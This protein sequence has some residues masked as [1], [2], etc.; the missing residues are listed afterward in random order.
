MVSVS[1][2][3]FDAVNFRE[4]AEYERREDAIFCA[5]VL[6]IGFPTAWISVPLAKYDYAGVWHTVTPSAAAGDL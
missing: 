3:V 4:D 2:R 1:R 6:T 5:D